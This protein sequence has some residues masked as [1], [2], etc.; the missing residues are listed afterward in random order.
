MA[1]E[2]FSIPYE[3]T[4]HLEK[5]GSYEEFAMWLKLKILYS[6]H[7]IIYNWTYPMLSTLTGI[8]INTLKKYVPRLIERGWAEEHSGH[9]LLKGWKKVCG[10]RTKNSGIIH[11]TKSMRF[12][13]VKDRLRALSIER[14]YK[15]QKFIIGLRTGR[16]EASTKQMV[17]WYKK[18]RDIIQN[19]EAKESNLILT[20]TRRIAAQTGLSQSGAYM[21][22]RRLTKNKIIRLK[23]IL[24]LIDGDC[25][26]VPMIETENG[27]LYWSD[28]RLYLN[29]GHSI[30]LFNQ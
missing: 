24:Q 17:K 11:V 27:Y 4:Q 22:A 1:T 25:N 14:D 13:E 18:Y 6:N 15:T 19:G 3:F 21:L 8:S 9:L 7:T 30:S 29:K 12:N 10:S 26:H 20:S 28:R 16:L 5:E 2:Y 23:P